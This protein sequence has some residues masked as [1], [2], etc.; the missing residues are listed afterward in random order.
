MV[1]S[2]LLFIFVFLPLFALTYLLGAWL[3]KIRNN[4]AETE[5]EELNRRLM[6]RNIA[7][8]IFSLIFYSW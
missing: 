3:D 5:G 6:W 2:D 1:F 4:R 7:V 8:V